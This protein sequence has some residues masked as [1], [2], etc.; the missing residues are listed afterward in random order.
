MNRV[1]LA[2]VI[3]ALLGASAV[4][5]RPFNNGGYVRGFSFV[6]PIDFRQE[7]QISDISTHYSVI[8]DH[9]SV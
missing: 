4:L 8:I 9:D 6:A 7:T 2:C 5:A 1:T 3:V